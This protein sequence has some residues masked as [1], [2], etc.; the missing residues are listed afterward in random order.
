MCSKDIGK[1]TSP[2]LMVS[3]RSNIVTVNLDTNVVG[4][5]GVDGYII[6]AISFDLVNRMLYW[7][8]INLGVIRRVSFDDHLNGS[9][10]ETIVTGLT[11]PEQIAVDWVNRKL[12]WT[13]HRRG[14]IERSDLDGTNIEVIVNI[15]I[16]PQAIVV[17]PFHK[18]IYWVNYYS[19]PRTIQRLSTNG[20]VKHTILNVARPS[21]LTIDYDNNLL[22][23]TDDQFNRLYSSDLAGNNIKIVPVSVVITQPYAIT[24]FQSKLYWTDRLYSHINIVNQFTGVNQGSI[25]A[26]LNRPTGI[27]V[28]D[29]SRQPGVCKSCRT[30]ATSLKYVANLAAYYS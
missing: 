23:W 26:S 18:T 1:D 5:Y 3:N 15:E 24:V 29:Y 21:G 11:T 8:E 22:Y 6:F 14:V 7:S 20:L 25:S 30:I 4:Q 9:A 10:V 19:V 13:D 16:V 28:I 17:D 2:I 27:H 12:Y